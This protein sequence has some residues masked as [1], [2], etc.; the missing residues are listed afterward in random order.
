MFGANRGFVCVKIQIYE[1]DHLIN[2]QLDGDNLKGFLNSW[3]MTLSGLKTIPADDQ[4]ECLFRKELEKS[5]SFE[6]IMNQYWQDHTINGHPK[7]YSKLV[8]KG[9]E[10]Y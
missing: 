2:V 9:S 6:T 8:R 7:S 4:L 1:F 5:K 3:N 10:T